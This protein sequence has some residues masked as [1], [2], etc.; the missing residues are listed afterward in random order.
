[1][2]ECHSR[3]HAGTG[4]ADMSNLYCD[5]RSWGE[6]VVLS[7]RG[8]GITVDAMLIAAAVCPGATRRD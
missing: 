1:M 2:H 7:A 4:A 5:E 6:N 8:P 3:Q